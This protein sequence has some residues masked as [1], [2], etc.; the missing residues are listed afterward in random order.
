[1]PFDITR[2]FFSKPVS[3]PSKTLPTLQYPRDSGWSNCDLTASYVFTSPSVFTLS[4]TIF[5]LSGCDRALSTQLDFPKSTNILSVP[6]EINDLLLSI[7]TY[8]FLGIGQG[9]SSKLVSPL[10]IFCNTCFILIFPHFSYDMVLFLFATSD[11]NLNVSKEQFFQLYNLALSND[12]L[13]SVVRK[14]GELI[15]SK[16]LDSISFWFS[17][18]K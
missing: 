4:K 13:D 5:T 1:M 15:S 11:K 16:I 8:P 3:L 17:G 7:N 12:L 2:T 18:L 14:S 6:A 10:A 9:T